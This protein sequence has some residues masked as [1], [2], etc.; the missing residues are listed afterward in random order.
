MFPQR[1]SQVPQKKADPSGPSF[2]LPAAPTLVLSF[3]IQMFL[4]KEEG[5]VSP[6]KLTRIYF[7][8][9]GHLI[10]PREERRGSRKFWLRCFRSGL[11]KWNYQTACKE[12]I[13]RMV[14]VTLL[15][16]LIL[17][18]VILFYFIKTDKK[19]SYFIKTDKKKSYFIKTDKN[20]TLR[21]SAYILRN[22]VLGLHP[23]NFQPNDFLDISII[24]INLKT[25]IDRRLWMDDQFQKLGASPPMRIEAILGSKYLEDPSSEPW[26]DSEVH[27]ILQEAV[28]RGEVTAPE[29]GCLLSHI[30]TIKFINSLLHSYLPTLVLEDDA[31]ISCIGLWPDSLS[32]YA[33]RLPKN[34]S[35]APVSAACPSDIYLTKD[36]QIQS[37][38]EPQWRAQYYWSTAAYMINKQ[39]TEAF[40]DMFFKNG[41]L[42]PYFFNV[43]MRKSLRFVSDAAIFYVLDSP[44]IFIERVPRIVPYN[45]P[46]FMEST[47]HP[48]DTITHLIHAMKVWAAYIS[49]Y[50][51]V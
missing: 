41:V 1:S 12:H 7:W 10:F 27:S 11:P 23:P 17:L 40:N 21:E 13:M 36:T 34:W 29:I 31:D 25:N 22:R 28:L 33:K 45:I 9:R 8:G 42:T 6:E 20:K 15:L 39:C 24:Y 44:R 50:E 14:V 37:I 32:S 4:K 26:I 30:N 46:T 16:V 49:N 51:S 5:E 47:I 3:L 38:T 18:F 19:K 48:K 35:F 43:C 2:F